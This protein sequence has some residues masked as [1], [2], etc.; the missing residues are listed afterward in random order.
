MKSPEA[1]PDAQQL[2]VRFKPSHATKEP[3]PVLGP[4]GG[5]IDVSKSHEERLLPHLSE[6]L[7]SR[8]QGTLNGFD[9]VRGVKALLPSGRPAEERSPELVVPAPG[10]L[11]SSGSLHQVKRLGRELRASLIA[12]VPGEEGNLREDQ[13]LLQRVRQ[14]RPANAERRCG[15]L[16]LLS[17]RRRR[18]PRGLQAERSGPRSPG[19]RDHP[20]DQARSGGSTK[21]AQDPDAGLDRAGGVRSSRRNW[22]SARVAMPLPQCSRPIQ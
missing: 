8:G 19:R 2:K 3:D 14:A 22:Q 18:L 15:S 7:V 11:R 16:E 1:K 10:V 17:T 5:V 13:L 9:A 12:P 20:A 4:S 21:K 6:R